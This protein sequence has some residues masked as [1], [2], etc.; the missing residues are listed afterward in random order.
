MLEIEPPAVMKTAYPIAGYHNP[1]SRQ[2]ETPRRCKQVI[3]SQ[4]FAP[5][6]TSP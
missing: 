3:D 4:H 6:V 5:D 1:R 2:W